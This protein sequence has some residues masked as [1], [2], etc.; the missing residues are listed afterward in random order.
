MRPYE[1]RSKSGR[2]ARSTAAGGRWYNPHLSAVASGIAI[3]DVLGAGA[4][5]GFVGHTGEAATTP[6]HRHIEWH[7]TFGMCRQQHPWMDDPCH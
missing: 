3:G 4:V 2:C 7:P 5:I 6:P 1:A